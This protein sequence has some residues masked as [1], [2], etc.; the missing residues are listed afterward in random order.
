MATYKKRL[1]PPRSSQPN[2]KRLPPYPYQPL[3][4]P[5]FL[6]PSALIAIALIIVCALFL[7]NW[8]S[9]HYRPGTD[10]D[11]TYQVTGSPTLT[12][13]FINKVLK[14][15]HSP[16]AGKGQALYDYGTHYGIDPAY[17]LAFFL[18]ESS[19]GTQ[20]VATV[21]HA[22]GNIRASDGYPSYEGYRKYRTWE[23]GFKDWYRLISE[24][25]VKEWNLSTVDEI[26]PV[27]APM[28]DGN[29]EA[30]Y[31]DTVKRAVTTWRKGIVR[32]A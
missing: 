18:Q 29:D 19:F 12:A 14:S 30:N 10:V 25:Y 16:A 21:T 1:P 31:I 28:D 5:R 22:L 7:L 26:I 2:K 4:W 13:E 3:V 27:Y 23:E 11:Q 15:Y 9:G 32:V 8:I 17:A 24:Q 6:A 20:G